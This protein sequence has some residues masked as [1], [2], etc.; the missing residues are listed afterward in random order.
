MQNRPAGRLLPGLLL[1]PLAC[2]GGG[3]GPPPGPGDTIPPLIEALSPAPGDTGVRGDA[4]IS[5]T[6]SEVVNPATVATASFF[7]QKNFT[8]ALVP[9]AY[10][11]AGRTAT[12]APVAPLESLTVYIATLTRAVRDSAGNQLAADTSWE[13]RTRGGPLVSGPGLG[14]ERR[15]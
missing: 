14:R 6:F 10:S 11:Y 13:F 3:Q 4:T 9:L 15:P 5:V 1:V 2:G 8:P 12:A 7:L